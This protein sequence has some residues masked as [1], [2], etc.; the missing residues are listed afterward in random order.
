MDR[1]EVGLDYFRI[2]W[3]SIAQKVV[4]K[5]VEV[6]GLDSEQAAALRK[7]YLKP[8]HYYSVAG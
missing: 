5:A 3:F 8:N 7:V 6:Y 1:K 2:L 4:E